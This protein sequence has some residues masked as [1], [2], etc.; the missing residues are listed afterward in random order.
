MH[1]MKHGIATFFSIS[2][3]SHLPLLAFS[4][5]KLYLLVN[6]ILDPENV[7]TDLPKPSK[8]MSDMLQAGETTCS[9]CIDPVKHVDQVSS[10]C[11]ILTFK[12]LMIIESKHFD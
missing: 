5:L 12:L 1:K 7:Q 10:L 4:F 3:K 2:S 9:V 8:C 11:K 6:F